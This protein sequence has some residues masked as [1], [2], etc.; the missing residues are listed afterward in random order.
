MACA[1]NYVAARRRRASRC[2]MTAAVATPAAA[3]SLNA[4]LDPVFVTYFAAGGAAGA[5][6]RTVVSPL[7]RLKIIQSVPPRMCD[8]G[9]RC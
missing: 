1:R 5:A 4:F 6:S 8:V 2:A 9:G 3:W 7:E